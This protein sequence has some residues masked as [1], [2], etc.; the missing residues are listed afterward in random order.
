MLRASDDDPECC[1]EALILRVALKELD[2]SVQDHGACHNVAG[3]GK[4]CADLGKFGAQVHVP[5][6]VDVFCASWSV[7]V[8]PMAKIRA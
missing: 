8:T 2:P 6:M 1:T 7:F 3:E 4:L 5:G